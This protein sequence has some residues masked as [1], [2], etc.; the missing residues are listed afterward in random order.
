MSTRR[1]YL[2]GFGA[3]VLFDTVTQISLKL[4]TAHAGEFTPHLSWLRELF[5]NSWIYLAVLGYLGAFVTWMTLLKYAPIGPA[6]AASHLELVPVLIISV[7]VFGEQLTLAQI[8]GGLCIVLG[9]V[10]L[11]LSKAENPDA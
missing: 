5:L 3:L 2:L 8:L 11:S 7:V 6:F 4:V 10:C 9:V 1:F